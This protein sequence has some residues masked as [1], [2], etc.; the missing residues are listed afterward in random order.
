MEYSLALINKNI[1]DWNNGKSNPRTTLTK[2][3]MT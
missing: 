3:R 1:L 2:L